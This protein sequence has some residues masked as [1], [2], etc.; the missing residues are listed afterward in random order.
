MTATSPARLTF[1]QLAVIVVSVLVPVMVLL[2]FAP[3]TRY[4]LRRSRTHGALSA[5]VVRSLAAYNTF[6][7]IIHLGI[8]DSQH[9]GFAHARVGWGLTL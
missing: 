3:T 1:D 7:T 4:L 5:H 2:A 8:Q 9:C 6:T